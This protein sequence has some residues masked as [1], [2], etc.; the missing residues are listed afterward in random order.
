MVDNSKSKRPPV[1]KTKKL[2][3]AEYMKKDAEERLQ[4]L[5]MYLFTP[6][7]EYII[8]D[9]IDSAGKEL[10]D[11]ENKEFYKQMKEFLKT[12]R[13]AVGI[14]LISFLLIETFNDMIINFEPEEPNNPIYG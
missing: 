6:E 14:P 10:A 5:R 9:C 13:Y 12:K 3:R 4:E 1:S 7:F 11:T 2:T 8:N